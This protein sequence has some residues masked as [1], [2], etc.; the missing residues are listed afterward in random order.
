VL[1]GTM[2]DVPFDTIVATHHPEIHRYLRRVA[3]RAMDADDLSQETFLRAY[4]AYPKLPAD[5][6]VR[7]WL[8]AIA[9]NLCRNHHRSARRWSRTEAAVRATVVSGASVPSEDPADATLFNEARAVVER[10]V[11]EL[12]L[13]QRLAFTLR[14]LHDVEYAAI[15][16]SLHCSP[17]AARAHV[18]QALRKIR[19][20]LNGSTLSLPEERR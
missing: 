2:G 11:A 7:A 14:K 20:A 9:T 15:A 16:E 19:H 8:F 18:F 4:R 5:A 12:P 10:A 13:K 6:N 3:P 17:D 1:S